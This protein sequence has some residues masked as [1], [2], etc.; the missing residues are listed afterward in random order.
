[1]E[2]ALEA[3]MHIWRLTKEQAKSPDYGSVLQILHLR[4]IISHRQYEAGNRYREI[5]DAYLATASLPDGRYKCIEA[6]HIGSTSAPPNEERFFDM[7]VAS[8]SLRPTLSY[9]DCATMRSV[10]RSEMPETRITW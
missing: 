4:E 10:P 6:G 1:M 8:T 9:V 7:M 2:V 5:M 3:R